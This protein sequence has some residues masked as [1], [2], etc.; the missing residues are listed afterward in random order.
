MA[1]ASSDPIAF[2]EAAYRVEVPTASWLSGIVDAARATLDQGMGVTAMLYDATD[3]AR[4]RI[5]AVEGTGGGRAEALARAIERGAPERIRWTF[6]TSACRVA[7]EGPDWETTPARL[8]FA[9]WGIEDVLCANGVDPT[10][11]GC[12][13]TAPLARRRR[14]SVAARSRW[15]RV[16][17]HL[18]A[19]YRLHRRIAQSAPPP[20]VTLDAA[21]RLLDGPAEVTEKEARRGLREAVRAMDKA[22]G[23]A[24]R[25]APDEALEGWKAL[26]D[27]R[28]TLLDHFDSDGRR[29]VVA[30]RNTSD[31]PD[32]AELTER[33]RQVL[34][35]AALGHTNKLVAYELGITAS[36]VRVLFARA[37]KKLGASSREDA[38][39]RFVQRT[40]ALTRVP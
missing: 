16:A 10:G 24:R 37:A 36:T 1:G 13:L 35:Y 14:L 5:L 25:T 39:A 26:V 19:G 40:A 30:R 33:E 4:M 3:V 11:I 2:V 9:K 20:E 6:R 7:S 22:R 28:W 38:V 18:A 27:A 31:V 8:L 29:F 12:F 23:R 34:A 17:A 21:G 32:A 15:E